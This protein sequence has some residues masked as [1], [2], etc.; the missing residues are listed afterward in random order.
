MADPITV[1][2][3]IVIFI[4]KW[5]IIDKTKLLKFNKIIIQDIRFIKKHINKY[6]FFLYPKMGMKSINK[7]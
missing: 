4:K 2:K 6:D 3:L 5:Q 7:P 1:E